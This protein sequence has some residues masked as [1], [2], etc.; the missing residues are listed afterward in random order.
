MKQEFDNAIEK[1]GTVMEYVLLL[2]FI[3]TFTYGLLFLM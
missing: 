3:V 1:A 2:G